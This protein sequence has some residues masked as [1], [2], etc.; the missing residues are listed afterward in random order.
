MLR[1]LPP[2]QRPGHAALS[3]PAGAREAGK[4]D[5]RRGRAPGGSPCS[6]AGGRRAR[7]RAGPALKPVRVGRLALDPAARR[8]TVGGKDLILTGYEFSLLYALASRAGRIL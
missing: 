2:H 5:C 6:R 1:D 3:R 8:A 4:R 7:G